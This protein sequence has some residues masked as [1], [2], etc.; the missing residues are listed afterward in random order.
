MNLIEWDEVEEVNKKSGSACPI[1]NPMLVGVRDALTFP[2]GVQNRHIGMS[3]TGIKMP[4]VEYS[5]FCTY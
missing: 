1:V 4:A 2:M 3:Q 5:R